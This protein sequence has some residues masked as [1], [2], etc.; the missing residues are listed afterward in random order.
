MDFIWH[1]IAFY[2][3]ITDIQYKH[4]KYKTWHITVP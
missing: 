1:N 2:T 3:C 4:I